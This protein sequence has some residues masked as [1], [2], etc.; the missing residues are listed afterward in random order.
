L[1]LGKFFPEFDGL[2]TTSRTLHQ[3]FAARAE[4]KKPPSAPTTA[5]ILTTT[6]L[7]GA[8][9]PKAFTA[10]QYSVAVICFSNDSL[11]LG[12]GRAMAFT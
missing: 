10:S 6:L 7:K 3:P 1:W 2:K 5:L 12:G 11:R 9:A 4:G 8:A